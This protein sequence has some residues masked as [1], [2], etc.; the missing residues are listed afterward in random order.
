MLW[1]KVGNLIFKTRNYIVST[2]VNFSQD[3]ET[4]FVVDGYFDEQHGGTLILLRWWTWL[5]EICMLF[6]RYLNND[7]PIFIKFVH[8]EMVK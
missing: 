1:T 4:K 6:D 7:T 3:V 2:I 5:Q 8:F